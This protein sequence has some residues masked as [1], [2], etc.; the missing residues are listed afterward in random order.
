[1][2]TKD[3]IRSRFLSSKPTSRI[4]TLADGDEVE[5]RQPKVG[6]Q[7]DLATIEDQKQRMLRMFV[8][9]V[10]MPGTNER[11]FEEGDYAA[12]VE[13]PAAGD[14]QKIMAALTDLMD[15]NKATAAAAKN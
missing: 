4:I 13:L 14:Y 5:I 9:N 10:Y 7:L 15:L 6:P 8:D 12:L 1:M 11:V 3:E 2:V